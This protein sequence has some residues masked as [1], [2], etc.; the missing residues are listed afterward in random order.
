MVQLLLIEAGII[1]AAVSFCV[2]YVTVKL[3]GP[4]RKKLISA[5]NFARSRQFF[6]E[7]RK[8]LPPK[9]R[10]KEKN[11]RM[12]FETT[13]EHSAILRKV[14]SD[15]KSQLKGYGDSLSRVPVPVIVPEISTMA[16]WSDLIRN[17][18]TEDETDF[19][20]SWYRYTELLREHSKLQSNLYIDIEALVKEKLIGYTAVNNDNV[21]AAPPEN[22]VFYNTELVASI[23]R[24]WLDS[25]R[26]QDLH[27]NLENGTDLGMEDAKKY[28][29]IPDARFLTLYNRK[30]GTGQEFIIEEFEKVARNLLLNFRETS[31]YDRYSTRLQRNESEVNELETKLKTILEKME[32]LPVFKGICEY[33]R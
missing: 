16:L 7:P 17:H 9:A 20:S 8:P 3:S 26:G 2:S 14:A 5:M 11:K 30:I 28:V 27:Y 29:K 18:M 25:M 21:N 15:M 4:G 31:L 12:E 22:T 33:S 1:S 10:E 23:M 32:T 24:N 19:E 6:S 13:P